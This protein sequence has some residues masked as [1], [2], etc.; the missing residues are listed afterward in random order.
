MV[1]INPREIFAFIKASRVEPYLFFYC[2][3]M[4]M[5]VI[6]RGQL[7]QDKLCLDEFGQ[8]RSFCVNMNSGNLTEKEEVM[9]SNVLKQSAQYG[10]YQSFI[11]TIPKFFWAVT[12]GPW[13]DLYIHGRKVMMGGA[14]LGHALESIVLL[15]SVLFFDQV[16]PIFI[17]MSSV[18]TCLVGGSM[19]VWSGCYGY[20]SVN[21]PSK[22]LASRMMMIEVVFSV[23]WTIGTYMGGQFLYPLEDLFSGSLR[24]YIPL[25]AIATVT[26]LIALMWIM[27]AINERKLQEKRKNKLDTSENKETQHDKSVNNTG[28]ELLTLNE[29]ESANKSEERHSFWELIKQ[30]FS[31]RNI[32]ELGKS[33][34]RKRE[35]NYRCQLILLFFSM[36]F[37]KFINDGP[38]M[39]LFAFVQKVYN[40]DVVML[41]NLKSYLNIIGT[42]A[43]LLGVPILEKW[44]KISHSIMGAIA[45]S[46]T[47]TY[48]FLVGIWLNPISFLVGYF[49][50]SFENVSYVTTRALITAI[51]PSNEIG[52]IFSALEIIK[53]IVPM[54]ASV[55]TT[56]IFQLT[57]DTQPGLVYLVIA[58]V[59]CFPLSIYLW[60]HFQRDA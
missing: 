51:L 17:L 45:I 4:A 41:S 48:C 35:K 37:T 29:I 57:I 52:K 49:A 30:I 10:M 44:F 53:A 60:I 1:K 13:T 11:T 20:A 27:F 33:I 25:Y 43:M 34:I 8:S 2:C 14:S 18:P 9:K 42:L 16:G 3:A 24:N 59:C 58:G 47:F 36:F 54:F 38:S 7:I 19:G 5:T 39:V 22:W 21:S 31:Y 15:I 46:S 6:S 28:H 26:Q 50:S 23:S 32:I 12:M 56:K 55:V 40:W